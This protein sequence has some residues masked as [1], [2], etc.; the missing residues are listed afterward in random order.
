MFLNVLLLLLNIK[1]LFYSIIIFILQYSTIITGNIYSLIIIKK[2]FK[3]Y[4][5][6][7]LYITNISLW[8][9]IVI[10][11]MFFI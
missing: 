1:C 2:Y 6:V 8:I 7:L 11:I 5:I 9:I 3:K 10:I 4:S